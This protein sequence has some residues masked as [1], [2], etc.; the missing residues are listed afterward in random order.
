MKNNQLT[1]WYDPD[2]T[3]N[4]EYGCI[5][6]RQWCE[7]ECVRLGKGRKGTWFSKEEIDTRNNLVMAIFKKETKNDK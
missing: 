1:N 2:S 4:S 7:F 3:I 6:F 5:K